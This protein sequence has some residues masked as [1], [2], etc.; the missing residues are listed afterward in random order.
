M[1]DTFLTISGTGEGF[2]KEKGSK[3]IAHAS[4]VENQDEVKERIAE[5]RKEY[6]DARHHCYAYML[7]HDSS[8]WRA[9][10]DGEPSNSAGTPI[11]NQ[12]RSKNLSNILVVVIRYF[13]GTKLG[14]S[15]LIRAYKQATFDA[16]E[17]AKIVEQILTQKLTIRFAYPAMNQVM[18]LIKDQDLKIL[19]QGYEDEN[20]M[21]IEVRN[22]LMELVIE[23][24]AKI[25]GL[26]I[27]DDF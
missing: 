9:N 13:G 16:L 11:L 8:V 22:R 18:K 2:Y 14:V 26:K 17:N 4:Y 1:L 10:D 15:G 23:K 12:I 27:D 7:G 21:Q 20:S 24:L 3:F 5:L 6:Y 19:S 25:D